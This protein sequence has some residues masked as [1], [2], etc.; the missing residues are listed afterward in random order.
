MHFQALVRAF[1]RPGNQAAIVCQMPNYNAARH[2]EF[3]SFPGIEI[4]MREGPI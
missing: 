2:H 3:Q 4:A 1:C